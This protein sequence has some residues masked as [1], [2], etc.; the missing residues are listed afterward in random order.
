M[1]IYLLAI[2]TDEFVIISI[3]FKYFE[4]LIIVVGIGFF[5][6]SCKSKTMLGF[7]VVGMLWIYIGIVYGVR[8]CKLIWAVT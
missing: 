1:V 5:I 3:P 6:T 8:Y 2:I 7:I 4:L